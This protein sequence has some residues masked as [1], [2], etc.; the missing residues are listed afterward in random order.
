M[1][2]V[3]LEHLVGG[4]HNGTRN[5]PRHY[6]TYFWRSVMGWDGCGE[7]SRSNYWRRVGS[8]QRRESQQASVGLFRCDQ[9]HAQDSVDAEPGVQRRASIMRL[10]VPGLAPIR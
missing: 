5:N 4:L 2:N 9:H 10:G 3:A 8:I 7:F 1:L 6:T